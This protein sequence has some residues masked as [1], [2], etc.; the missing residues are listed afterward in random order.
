MP[1]LL[2][3][4]IETAMRGEPDMAIVGSVEHDGAALRRTLDENGVDVVVVSS[5]N[6][7]LLGQCRDL[8]RTWPHVKV[9]GVSE[10][11]DDAT[12]YELEP[13]TRWLG[14]LSQIDLVDAIRTA[15]SRRLAWNSE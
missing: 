1:R 2:R 12:F 4:I 13:A 7:D 8:L 15:R 10:V 11:G 6:H 9:L 14:E 3:E 5:E